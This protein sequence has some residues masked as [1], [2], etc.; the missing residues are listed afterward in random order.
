MTAPTMT[1]A[2]PESRKVAGAGCGRG[3]RRVRGIGISPG[4]RAVRGAVRVC[5]A[6]AR[7][8]AQVRVDDGCDGWIGARLAAQ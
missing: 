1:A 7:Q 2:Q 8:L 4:W 5:S 3:G 6:V